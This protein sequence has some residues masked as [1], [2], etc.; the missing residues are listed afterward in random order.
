M[1]RGKIITDVKKDMIVEFFQEGKSVTDISTALDISKS[2]VVRALQEKG[3]KDYASKSSV[4]SKLDLIIELLE[5]KQD[6]KEITLSFESLGYA[7]RNGTYVGSNVKVNMNNKKVFYHYTNDKE[8]WQT[9][10]I[11]PSV[12]EAIWTEMKERGWNYF[13]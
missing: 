10:I 6:E 1:P 8:Q 11:E 4:D 2:S 9:V 5:D 13:K 7:D 3:L 12:I